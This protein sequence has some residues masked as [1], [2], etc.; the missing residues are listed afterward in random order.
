VFGVRVL[1]QMII[2]IKIIG[3]CASCWCREAVF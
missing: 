3:P 1:S 2:G